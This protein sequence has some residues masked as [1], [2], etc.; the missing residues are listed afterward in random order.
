MDYLCARW[1]NRSTTR[2]L[3]GR[4][5]GPHPNQDKGGKAHV[6]TVGALDQQQDI[7]LIGV[8]KAYN[9]GRSAKDTSGDPVASLMLLFLMV[10]GKIRAK[11]LTQVAGTHNKAKEIN[12]YNLIFQVL[13]NQERC[14]AFAILD[15]HAVTF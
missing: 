8:I 13:T 12:P 9:N 10:S 15:I 6:D 3:Q 7:E 1:Q 2:S 5:I 11:N 14:K 4:K